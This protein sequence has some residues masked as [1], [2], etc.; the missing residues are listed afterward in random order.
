MSRDDAERHRG[1]RG[2]PLS[3]KADGARIEER[4]AYMPARSRNHFSSSAVDRQLRRRC[5]VDCD[6]RL[7]HGI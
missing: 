1:Q 3:P 7:A 5:S 6:A 4:I 2:A